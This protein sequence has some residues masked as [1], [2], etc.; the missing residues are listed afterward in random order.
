MD[1]NAPP[2]KRENLTRRSLKSGSDQDISWSE[3][4]AHTPP[5]LVMAHLPIDRATF[6]AISKDR[7]LVTPA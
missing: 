5:E 2:A 3:W 4:L 1:P 6:D 7:I